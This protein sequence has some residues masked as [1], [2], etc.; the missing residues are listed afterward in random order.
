[1]SSTPESAENKINAEKTNVE[2][3]LLQEHKADAGRP[4]IRVRDPEICERCTEKSCTVCC[5]V[6]CWSVNLQGHIEVTVDGCLE[7]GTCRLVCDAE[8]VDW[9]FPR[10]GYGVLY[11]FG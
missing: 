6:G 7:C 5:P 4:S 11:K 1:M 3:Q 2:E 8:N 10:V 9:S